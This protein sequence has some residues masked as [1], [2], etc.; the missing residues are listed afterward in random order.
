M[1]RSIMQLTGK[2][3]GASYGENGQVKDFFSMINNGVIADTGSWLFRGF[4]LMDVQKLDHL[5]LGRETGHWFSGKQIL[6]SQNQIDRIR[7]EASKVFAK[8]TKEAILQAP[9]Y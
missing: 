9:E 7:C 1:L 2:A 5:S 8:V 6:I 3:L 4:F